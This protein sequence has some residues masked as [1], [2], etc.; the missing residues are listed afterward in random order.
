MIL[1]RHIQE[2]VSFKTPSPAVA[3]LYLDLDHGKTAD[4]AFR[5]LVKG[6]GHGFVPADGL[7]ALERAINEHAAGRERGLAVFSSPR[8]GLLRVCPLPQPVKSRLSLETAPQLAPLLNL[9]DQHQRYGVALVSPRRARFLEYFM[10]QARELREHETRLQETPGHDVFL[11][12][13][14]AKLDVLSRQLGFQRL[15]VGAAPALERGLI[16]RLHRSLQDNVILDQ[17]LDADLPLEEVRARI[18]LADAQARRVRELV[19][20]HRLIDRRGPSVALGLGRA[21]EA[22]EHRRV[23]LLLVRDGFAKLGRS[24]LGCRRLSLVDIKCDFCGAATETVFNLVDELA[25]RA[26]SQGADV[27]RLVNQTPLDNL[28]HIGAELRDIIGAPSP[29]DNRCLAP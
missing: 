16:E 24:C 9:T 22:V 5:A 17:A 19:L 27:F 29:S 7:A 13:V 6:L 14:A 28:G 21:L 3:S 26:V 12:A 10:D 20:A 4:A 8:F 23:R 25:D 2:L 11:K 15:I 18:A 1:S